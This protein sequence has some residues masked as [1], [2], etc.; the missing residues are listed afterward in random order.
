MGDPLNIVCIGAHPDDCEIYAG[1][2]AAKWALAGH[3][4]VFVCTTNGDAGHHEMGGGVL[5]KVRA[6]EAR[7]SADI[8]GIHSLILDNHD[9]ELEPTLANRKA[10][11]RVIREWQADVVIS[12]KP[13]DYHPD[14]RYTAQL[15]QDAAF[16]VTVPNFAPDVP[17]LRHNPVFLYLMNRF[18]RPYPFQ[19]DIAV[20]IGDTIET[21]FAMADAMTSQVYEWLPWLNGTLD[22][23]PDDAAGRLRWLKKQWGPFFAQPAKQGTKALTKWYGPKRAAKVKY[24]ELFELCEYGSQPSAAEI[25]RLFPFFP[26]RRS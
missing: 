14:H 4:V 6:E 20:D 18:K 26:N 22:S 25:R 15:V 10:L 2:T 17:A 12:H 23:V 9:G 19:A 24:A 3:R 11:T 5:A 13:N 1:G 7:R 8:G 21:K 16:M